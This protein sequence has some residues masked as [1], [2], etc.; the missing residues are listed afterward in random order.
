METVILNYIN[1]HSRA[2]LNAKIIDTLNR[3]VYLLQTRFSLFVCIGI[4]T[5]FT[6]SPKCDTYTGKLDWRSEREWLLQYI[7][8]ALFVIYSSILSRDLITV[9]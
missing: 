2:I 8:R 7:Y 4:C 9:K 1:I 5:M 6:V 3:Q